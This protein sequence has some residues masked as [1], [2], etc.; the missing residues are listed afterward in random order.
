MQYKVAYALLLGVALV[1]MLV[2]PTSEARNYRLGRYFGGDFTL[3]D[4]N[5]KRF[6]LKDA[7]GKVVVIYFGFTSCADVCPTTLAKV[8]MAMRTLGPLAEHVQSLFIS[9]DARRDTPQVLR[10]YVTS[11]HP[12]IIG[13]TGTQDEVEAVARQYRMPVYVR[14]PD[15]NGSY[16][17]D[18]GSKLYLVDAEGMLANVLQYE[19]SPDKIASEIR[20]LLND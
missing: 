10:V 12:D 8:S 13:L 9:V 4:H 16:V 17:V 14:S 2:A 1:M 20:D 7:R 15:E 5:R 3:T 11:F 19:A 18:H 6:S